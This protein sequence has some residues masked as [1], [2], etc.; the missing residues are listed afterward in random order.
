MCV[1]ENWVENLFTL[2]NLCWPLNESSLCRVEKST[3]AI[4]LYEEIMRKDLI[5]TVCS[6][7][8]KCIIVYVTMHFGTNAN[9]FDL[10]GSAK[11]SLWQFI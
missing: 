7:N 5:T 1:A 6:I 4:S 9:S 3:I 8:R 11:L 2:E 10:F